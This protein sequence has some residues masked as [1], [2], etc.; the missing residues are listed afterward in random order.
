MV[1]TISNGRALQEV[2]S[3]SKSIYGRNCINVFGSS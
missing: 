2:V 3:V 1:E